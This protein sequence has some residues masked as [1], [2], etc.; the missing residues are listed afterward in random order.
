M[1]LSV[2]TLSSSLQILI[3]N[4]SLHLSRK[5]RETGLKSSGLFSLSK[6]KPLLG[7]AYI[8]HASTD[9]GKEIPTEDL[10]P[11]IPGIGINYVLF[12]DLTII[13]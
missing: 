11:S 4:R 13:T 3:S 2:S 8:R 12:N 1:L 5:Y 9:S 7:A 6:H 10:L